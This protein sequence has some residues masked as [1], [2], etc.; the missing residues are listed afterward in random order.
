MAATR[1]VLVDDDDLLAELL[2]V[3]FETDERFDLVGRA[4]NGAEGIEL[5]EELGPDA[6]LMDLHMPLV[7]GIEATRL[8]IAADPDACVIAF[9]SSRDAGELAQARAAGAAA[10]LEKPFDPQPFLDAVA[11]HAHD[12]RLR[13]A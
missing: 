13:A 1:I 5:V 6:V 4:R 9:T 10:V 2:R 11:E 12:C 8:L 7:G 3:N